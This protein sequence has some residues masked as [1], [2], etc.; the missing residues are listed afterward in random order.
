[1][2]TRTPTSPEPSRASIAEPP[3]VAPGPVIVDPS[4]ATRGAARPA[5]WRREGPDKLTGRAIYVDD[6]VVPGA[7]YGATIRSTEAHARFLGLDLDPDFDW[8]RVVI[9]TAADIPGDNVIAAI[10][11]DQPVLVTDEIR[12]HAEPVALLAAADRETLRAARRAV[13]LRTQ[14]LPRDPRPARSRTTSSPTTRSASAMS[15]RRSPP[16]TWS[17]R[18]PTGSATR[19]SCTSRTRA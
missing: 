14:P 16:P 9:V 3:V 10:Q 5:P 2:I 7:W 17:S 18:A 8:T 6:L 11:S 19:S 1:M 12:H 15:M 13:R 4:G